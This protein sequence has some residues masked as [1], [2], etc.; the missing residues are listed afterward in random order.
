MKLPVDI[1]DVVNSV[2]DMDEMRS[3]PVRVTLIIDPSA[4]KDLIDNLVRDF[5]CASTQARTRIGYID[6]P[7]EHLSEPADMAV[8]VAGFDD[9]VG[10]VLRSLRNAGIPALVVTTMPTLVSEIAHA[11]ATPIE[12]E[13]IAY[14]TYL[15]TV[16]Y[17]TGYT[18]VGA[19]GER[20]TSGTRVSQADTVRGDAQMRAQDDIP[21]VIAASSATARPHTPRDMSILPKSLKRAQDAERDTVYEP[22]ELTERAY[23]SLCERIA[24]WIIELF[25]DKLVPFALSYE[26]LSEFMAAEFVR[27]T[28]VQNAGI[29]VVVFIPGADMPLMTGNQIKMLFQIAACY[30]QGISFGRA[31]ELAAIIG[32]GYLCRAVARQSV[33]LVPGL[34]WAIKGTIGYTGT[35]AMG[36]GVITYFERTLR[37]VLPVYEAVEQARD[38]ARTTQELIKDAPT[39]QAAVISS[40]KFV[41]EHAKRGAMKA[42]QNA[43]PALKDV[44][45]GSLNYVGASKELIAKSAAALSRYLSK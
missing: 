3:V 1:G 10:F 12:P 7:I 26:F 15:D 29:G 42:A 4:P 28:A 43:L 14:P 13:D 23:H 25:P 34:G 30:G 38:V 27:I 45:Q 21:V 31:K 24:R 9:Y 11:H 40:A 37:G 17:S 32:G 16:A 33:G 39:P 19:M 5:S 20:A 18:Q 6:D 41:S 8:I 2:I 44:A 35:I 22:I 36:Y